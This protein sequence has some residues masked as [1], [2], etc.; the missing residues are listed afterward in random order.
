MKTLWYISSDRN[1]ARLLLLD[2]GGKGDEVPSA[3]SGRVQRTG[4]LPDSRVRRPLPVVHARPTGHR[5]VL[6][7]GGRDWDAGR[8]GGVEAGPESGGPEGA[9]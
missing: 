2:G 1:G 6:L 5:L 3:V 9:A 8:R 4:S 7:N